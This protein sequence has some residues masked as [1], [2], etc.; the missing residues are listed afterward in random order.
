MNE[1]SDTLTCDGADSISREYPS[2][3]LPAV[4]AL[5][6]REGKV[7][8]VKR[9]HQPN[10][11]RWSVPGGLIELG[12]T[13]HEAAQRELHE[14]CGIEIKLGEV[15]RVVDNIVLD[16]DERVRFHYVLIYLLAQYVSGTARPDSDAS[17]VRWVER[18]ELDLLDMHPQARQTVQQMFERV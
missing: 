8:L 1:P 14:E 2:G 16:G 9:A 3:P 7:L 5:T 18:Q 17:E 6:Y 11:G 10:K 13:V 4:F 12:E 15:V